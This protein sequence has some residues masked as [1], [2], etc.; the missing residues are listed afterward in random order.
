MV[1][2]E[3]KPNQLWETRSHTHAGWRR[4]KVVNV[5]LGAVELQYLDSP[6][7]DIATTFAMTQS[8]MLGST[9][10]QACERRAIKRDADAAGTQ[11][12]SRSRHPVG[13]MHAPTRLG[14][15]N[16]ATVQSQR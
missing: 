14:P 15:L 12:K 16:P 2:V 8:A 9:A 5:S 3:V 6:A 11:C 1:R 10:I 13:G 4:V 7:P